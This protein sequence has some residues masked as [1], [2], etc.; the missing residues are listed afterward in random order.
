MKTIKLFFVFVWVIVVYMAAYVAAIGVL[1]GLF[2][3]A[4]A[5]I[6]GIAY[7]LEKY[8]ARKERRATRT[9]EIP[10]RVVNER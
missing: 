10:F 7:L 8:R 1:W 5:G 2:Y 6:S 9:M 4:V 3:A